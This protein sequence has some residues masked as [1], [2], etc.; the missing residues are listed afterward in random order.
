MTF[1]CRRLLIVTPEFHGYW[2]SIERAFGELGYDVVTHRYDAAPPREKLYNKLRH[3]LPA[4]ISGSG[5]HLSDHTVTERALRAL[6]ESRADLLLVVRGDPLQERF[7]QRAAAL[8]IPIVV[9]LYDEL[10]RMRHNPSLLAQV[11]RIATYSAG[12]VQTLGAQG[13]A[14]LHVPLAFDPSVEVAGRAASG[15]V[16]FIGARFPKRERY[17]RHLVTHGIPVRAHGRDWSDHPADR[18]RTWRSSAVGVPNGRDVP[19][20]D[21]YSV[22]RAGLATLNIHGDQDGFTMRTFEACGVGAVQ[23]IDRA[24]VSDFYSPGE[25]I[26]VFDSEAELL[27]LCRRVVQD[28]S[29][30]TRLR[31]AAHQRTVAQHTF[32]H[33]AQALQELWIDGAQ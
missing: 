13:I 30:L 1:P 33:R 21:G 26:L 19:L 17:L 28:R 8:S 27:E 20:T 22:M 32:K 14:A 2:R 9:W 15:E 29:G 7:W 11:A 25:E 16:T 12:D 18:A 3:E 10:R 24:D 4:Q 5:R 31:E 23:L 6:S